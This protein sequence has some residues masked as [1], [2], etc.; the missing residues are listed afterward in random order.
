MKKKEN[1]ELM[2][3]NFM[4]TNFTNNVKSLNLELSIWKIY[5]IVAQT[6]I[7]QVIT[8]PKQIKRR[9]AGRGDYKYILFNFVND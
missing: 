6:K 2:V 4:K 7:I 1:I 9:G 5:Q 3:T 8:K